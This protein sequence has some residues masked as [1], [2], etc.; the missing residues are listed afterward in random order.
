MV[1]VECDKVGDKAMD[2]RMNLTLV[3]NP[4][5]VDIVRNNGPKSIVFYPFRKSQGPARK[6]MSNYGSMA[7]FHPYIP[8]L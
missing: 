1:N 8:M 2:Q 3:W 6:N 4:W 5:I 7:S